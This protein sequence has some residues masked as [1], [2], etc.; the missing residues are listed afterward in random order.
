[1][2]YLDVEIIRTR[3]HPDTVKYYSKTGDPIAPFET[4]KPGL[5]ESA[6]AQPRWDYYSTIAKKAAVQH[7][8]MVKNHAFD[9]GNKRIA[10]VALVT[11]LYINDYVFNPATT[12]D[13]NLAAMTLRIAESDRSERDVVLA[14]TERWVQDHIMKK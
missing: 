5:L 7:Y 14:E 11:F 2:Y 1:M 3:C 4:V 8:S 9:N 13:E 10:V 12:T 6:L